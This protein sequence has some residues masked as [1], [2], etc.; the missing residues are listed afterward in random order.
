MKHVKL[1]FK[2]YGTIIIAVLIIIVF[3]QSRIREEEIKEELLLPVTVIKPYYG[4]LE[5]KYTLNG[6]LESND[7]V[8]VLPKVSGTLED[9]RVEVGEFVERDDIIGKIDNDQLLLALS[10][11][12]SAYLSSK[13]IFERQEFLFNTNSTSK[14]NY[15]QAK[16]IY[17]VN[18]AQY[19]LANLQ[20]SYSSIKAPISG[21]ILQIH[22]NEG[23][24]VSPGTPIVT[25]GTIDDLIFKVKIPEKYYEY[26]YLNEDTMEIVLSRPDY[27]YKKY[28][29]NIRY[30][31]P[32]ID[33]NTMTFEVVCDFKDVIEVLRPGMFMNAKFILEKVEDIYYLPIESIKNNRAWYVDENSRANIISITTSFRNDS[34]VQ[35]ESSLSNINF[36]KEGFYFLTE[37]QE[38]NVLEVFS[39]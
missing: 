38:V 9:I 26:F 2:F 34:F 14:Q 18:K 39:K 28:F 25:I 1:D 6:Y 17:E 33:P 16:S 3:T 19:E 36:I 8:I 22:T 35:I 12:R 37:G 7:I 31:S 24:L 21:T 30:L 32:V 23:S 13:D 4:S 15:E 10:Q 5:K 29:T 27:P 20:L 11:A